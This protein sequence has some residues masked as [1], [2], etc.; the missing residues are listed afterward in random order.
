MRAAVGGELMLFNSAVLQAA[1]RLQRSG[2][3]ARCTALRFVYPGDV[4]GI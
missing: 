3:F 1:G 4:L 2:G